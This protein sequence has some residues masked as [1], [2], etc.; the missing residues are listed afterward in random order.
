MTISGFALG[1]ASAYP[2]RS[3]LGLFDPVAEHAWDA[4]YPAA[5]LLIGLRALREYLLAR[6]RGVFVDEYQ[7]CSIPQH[8]LVLRLADILPCRLVLDPLQAIFDF[9][10]GV[11]DVDAHIAPE[12]T[13]FP[14]LETPY[15]WLTSNPD[16]GDWLMTARQTLLGGGQIDL[17]T[18]PPT[19]IRLRHDRVQTAARQVARLDGSVVAIGHRKEDTRAFARST[20]GGFAAMETV[21]CPELVA[22][23]R[24]IEESTG[25]QRGI[26]LLDLATTCMTA[27]STVLA[28]SRTALLR[29]RAPTPHAGARNEAAV[30]A[31]AVVVQENGLGPVVTAMDE[32]A[33]LPG[34]RIHRAE[35]W[36][37]MREAIRENVT[38]PDHS[39]A[40]IAWG[41]RN[42]LRE[43]GR[44]V[45]ALS[46]SYPMLIK[47]L[48]FDHAL[49]LDGG[50]HDARSLYVAITRA[51][52]SLTVI[53]D[54]PVLPRPRAP[55]TRR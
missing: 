13:R 46:A 24:S 7:D 30:S 32:I 3:G 39:L 2:T 8:E 45:D 27:V 9:G 31:L 15:R 49:I 4:V 52:Q 14:D 48:E 37:A 23:A 1:L 19:H 29:G 43:R 12:F 41:H 38:T 18:G 20:P 55:R 54:S 6:Y 34:V 33:A 26:A 35:L 40:D 47:G 10:G 42:A 22:A 51:R 53:S 17:R 28:T 25:L 16:L 50:R 21:D 5:T 11:V 44:A 36:S